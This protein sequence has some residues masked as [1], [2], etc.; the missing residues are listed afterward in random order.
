MTDD[1]RFPLLARRAIL[2]SAAHG[3]GAIAL[4]SLLRPELFATEQE[5]ARRYFG[6]L[7]GLPHHPPKAKHVI[8]LTQSGGPSQID[9]F[10]P[11]PQLQARRGEEIP[12]AI[13]KGQRLTTMTA[14][15]ASK[16]IAPSPFKF[17]RHG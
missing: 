7:P 1:Y 8:F 15:Q 2:S 5:S 9:L 13:R 10:D 4:A 17:A 16:P 12:D 3:L 11:K 14:D 6:A